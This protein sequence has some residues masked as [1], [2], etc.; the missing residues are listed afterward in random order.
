MAISQAEAALMTATFLV[1]AINFRAGLLSAGSSESHQSRACVSRRAR[2]KNY[3]QP[4]NSL[5]GSG[6]KNSGPT[7]SL[8]FRK[9][10]CRLPLA[11]PN[12][13]R[14]AT[15]L[16]P[17]AIITSSPDEAFLINRERLVFA[18]WIVFG[19]ASQ[20]S[21]EYL[22]LWL[23]RRREPASHSPH[24]IAMAYLKVATTE[25]CSVG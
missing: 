22:H 23:K 25:E 5:A 9:P 4:A 7:C 19:F 10:G 14:R 13:T 24:L 2:T 8:P 1:S 6:S 20:D 17:R 21:D 11:S 12:A 16:S 3:S 15:G 18:L